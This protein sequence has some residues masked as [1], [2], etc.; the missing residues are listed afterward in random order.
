MNSAWSSLGKVLGAA[1]KIE[2]VQYDLDVIEYKC[3]VNAM[4]GRSTNSTLHSV[5]RTIEQSLESM[6]YTIAAFLHS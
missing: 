4:K 3:Q 1:N 6:E 2:F 5:L